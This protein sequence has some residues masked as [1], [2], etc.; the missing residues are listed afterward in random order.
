MGREEGAAFPLPLG[1]GEGDKVAAEEG[2][3]GAGGESSDR[4]TRRATGC[5]LPRFKTGILEP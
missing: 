1:K 2:E 3:W 5:T 4:M